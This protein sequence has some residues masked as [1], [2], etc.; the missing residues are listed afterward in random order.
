MSNYI[1][2][3]VAQA[4]AKKAKPRGYMPPASAIEIALPDIAG[5]IYLIRK[6]SPV[7]Y[8]L[9]D[10]YLC[11]RSEAFAYGGDERRIKAEN[12]LDR[13]LG[14]LRKHNLRASCRDVASRS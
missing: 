5:S 9:K 13:V 1:D 12:L 11:A 2:W 7:P 3:E 4:E 14:S 8:K 10:E 6:Y